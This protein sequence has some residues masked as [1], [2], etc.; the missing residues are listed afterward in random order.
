[1]SLNVLMQH[2]PL[3]HLAGRRAVNDVEQRQRGWK[4]SVDRWQRRPRG[5]RHQ[6]AAEVAP[7]SITGGRKHV[8]W[9]AASDHNRRRTRGGRR[10]VTAED[11]H[12]DASC[13]AAT[14]STWSVMTD[15]GSRRRGVD[16]R[17]RRPRG[18]R[19]RTAAE[20]NEHVA[21]DVGSQ[22]ETPTWTSD[23]R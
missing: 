15:G 1:M 18:R 22:P 12:V 14:E 4:T 10:R 16:Q 6:T 23:G 5:T 3:R 21:G 13:S 20:E 19:R 2:K 8:A 7:D 17:R 11:A 9:R